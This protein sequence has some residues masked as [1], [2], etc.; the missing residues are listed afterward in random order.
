M[1]KQGIVV[2]ESEDG[3]V[4]LDVG[5][6]GQTVWLTQAQMASLFMTTKQNVSLHANNCFKEGELD[7][8]SVVKECLTT[9]ADGKRYR[10]KFFNLDVIISVGYLV[11]SQRGV[12]FR[13]WATGVLRQYI[14]AGQAENQR[15]LAQ[16]GKIVQVM[17]RVPESLEAGDVLSVVKAYTGALNLLDDYDHQRIVKPK[18][19]A[20][21]Y[22]LDYDECCKLIESMRFAHESDLFGVEKDDSFK[23]SIGCHIPKLRWSRV[24][25]E[26]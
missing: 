23:S 5:F 18:G 7:K 4:R 1:E 3:E 14:V 8:E 11:K 16:L 19:S 26:S 6:D 22:M 15:R 21:T 17:E 9:A 25:S 20:A 10:T 13:R 2:F 12:E 24:V